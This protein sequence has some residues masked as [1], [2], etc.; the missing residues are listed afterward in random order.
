MSQNLG[1]DVTILNYYAE[2]GYIA[3]DNLGSFTSLHLIANKKM[4]LNGYVALNS[5]ASQYQ[6]HSYIIFE[7]PEIVFNS[8]GWGIVILNN[9]YNSLTLLDSS[10]NFDNAIYDGSSF[11]NYYGKIIFSGNSSLNIT[12]NTK[13]KTIIKASTLT[14]TVSLDVEDGVQDGDTFSIEATT[15][16]LVITDG[17]WVATPTTVGKVTTY[18][19]TKSAPSKKQRLFYTYENGN[20]VLRFL[21]DTNGKQRILGSL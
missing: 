4:T 20:R 16:N 1:D 11:G 3:S 14:G 10:V 19:L 8:S 17:D 15:N 6:Y 21:T 13:G 12:S 18:T 7:A 5:S 2:D 9:N